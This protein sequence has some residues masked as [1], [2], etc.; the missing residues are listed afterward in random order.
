MTN[1]DE[2]LRAELRTMASP[3]NLP[4]GAHEM[5]MQKVRASDRRGGTVA[6][7][8][9]AVALVAVGASIALPRDGGADRRSSE[10]QAADGAAPSTAPALQG[11]VIVDPD[12]EY[13]K[14]TPIEAIRANDD[15]TQL[16][17]D[18]EGRQAECG[19]VV[20]PTR[21]SDHRRP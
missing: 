16:M 10:S 8:V 1:E 3:T 21:H 7:V 14:S 2:R 18:Y 19:G 4:T 20:C 11:L 12:W 5:I 15:G 13:W 6:L 9:A 17:L